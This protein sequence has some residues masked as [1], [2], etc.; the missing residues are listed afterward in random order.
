MRSTI[1]VAVLIATT[2]SWITG[3]SG[4]QRHGGRLGTRCHRSSLVS[5]PSSVTIA[6]ALGIRMRTAAPQTKRNM[7]R[8]ARSS[9]VPFIILSIGGGRA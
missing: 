1:I 7:A 6:A 5:H 8:S 3:S 9:A 2:S 4:F